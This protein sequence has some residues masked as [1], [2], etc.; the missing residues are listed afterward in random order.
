[1][2][3]LMLHFGARQVPTQRTRAPHAVDMEDFLRYSPSRSDSPRRLAARHALTCSFRLPNTCVSLQFF[4]ADT[5][6]DAGLRSTLNHPWS[7]CAS[8]DERPAGVLP[9]LHGAGHRRR[10]RRPQRAADGRPPR[11]R[12]DDRE[13][14]VREAAR[15]R[16]RAVPTFGDESRPVAEFTY[17][18]KTFFLGLPRVRSR[19]DRSGRVR[20]E[21][22]AT[23]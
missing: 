16:E 23:R 6:R 15:H 4:R 3:G 7:L 21:D 18:A 2:V 10:G 11:L 20:S 12:G 9:A 17:V 13:P 1:M 22:E 14:R 19:R 8:K 5:R